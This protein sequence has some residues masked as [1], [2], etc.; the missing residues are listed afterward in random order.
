MSKLVSLPGCRVPERDL[1]RRRRWSRLAPAKQIRPTIG[2]VNAPKFGFR[3]E[4]TS[5]NG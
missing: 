1:P 4:W 2:A 3:P 5:Q